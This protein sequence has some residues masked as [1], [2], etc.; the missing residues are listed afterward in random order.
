MLRDTGC[1][2]FLCEL[3]PKEEGWANVAENENTSSPA[4]STCFKCC[5]RL[6]SFGATAVIPCELY[7]P[8]CWKTFA[9][10][11]NSS[12]HNAAEPGWLPP[13]SHQLRL[14]GMWLLQLQLLQSLCLGLGWGM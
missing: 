8:G 12:P 3:P 4:Q 10:S 7:A 14:A 6:F 11:V 5:G 9:A 1:F 2:G 13:V